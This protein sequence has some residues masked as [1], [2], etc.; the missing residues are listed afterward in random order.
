MGTY[1]RNI[2]LGL[3]TALKGMSITFMHLFTKSVTVQYPRERLEIPKG[4]RNLLHCNMDDCIGCNQCG[5]ACPVNCIEIETIKAF[6]GE[7]LGVT[8]DSRKKSLWVP[9]FN[10]DMAKCCYCGLCTFPC[11]TECLTMT[12]TFEYSKYSRD[13]LLFKFSDVDPIKAAELREKNEI[14]KKEKEAKKLAALK[15]KEAAAAKK[16]EDGGKEVS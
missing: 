11:P 8:S 4:S 15:A 9:V 10:I 6:E 3:S 16:K 7:D 2:Y 5:K 12:E 13:D 1:F 14:R